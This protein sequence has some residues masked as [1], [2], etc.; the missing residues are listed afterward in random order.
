M[1]LRPRIGAGEVSQNPSIEVE[2]AI[3]SQGI[4]PTRIRS[5]NAGTHLPRG[6]G[7]CSALTE[8]DLRRLTTAATSEIGLNGLQWRG[9]SVR[10]C[11]P[12]RPNARPSAMRFHRG[13]ESQHSQ[14][15]QHRNGRF[16]IDPIGRGPGLRSGSALPAALESRWAAVAGTGLRRCRRSPASRR[17][18]PRPA[19]SLVPAGLCE[20]ADS[21]VQLLSPS[22]RDGSRP[23]RCG[24]P[25]PGRPRSGCAGH[26]A[27]ER[28]A[29]PMHETFRGK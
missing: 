15:S 10:S 21:G 4:V 1:R 9:R 18:N 23:L 7:C 16:S 20:A 8:K 2:F 5:T 17:R 6:R 11:R 3:S 24:C 14:H 26:R 29:R 22:V 13:A 27:P 19:P 28:L 12:Q 25:Q